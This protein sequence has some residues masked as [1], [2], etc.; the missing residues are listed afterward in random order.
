M[1][2]V[3][4]LLAIEGSQHSHRRPKTCFDFCHRSAGKAMSRITDRSQS[5]STTPALLLVPH[6]SLVDRLNE[7]QD[8]SHLSSILPS[9][10]GITRMCRSH[11]RWS[12][13]LG[14]MDHHLFARKCRTTLLAMSRTTNHNATLSFP[15]TSLLPP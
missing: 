13:L 1:R 2:L 5:C 15:H 11:Y 14:K 10:H 6:S 3:A 12:T 8:V 9:S 7:E 4:S